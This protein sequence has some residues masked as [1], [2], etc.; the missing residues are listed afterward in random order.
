MALRGAEPAIEDI[1]RNTPSKLARYHFRDGGRLIFH[2][3]RPLI[4]LPPFSANQARE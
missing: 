4:A 1:P 3:A 2:C